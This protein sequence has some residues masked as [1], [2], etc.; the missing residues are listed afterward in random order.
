[1]SMRLFLFLPEVYSG[2]SSTIIGD[3]YQH[4]SVALIIN[5]SY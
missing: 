1:M 3:C 5:F 2:Q 4:A